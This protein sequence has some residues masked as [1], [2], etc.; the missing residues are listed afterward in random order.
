MGGL[1]N[2][3]RV[4]NVV[5]PT[6]RDYMKD[7]KVA[8]LSGISASACQSEPQ[9]SIMKIQLSRPLAGI[10][11]LGR[12]PMSSRTTTSVVTFLHPFVVAGYTGDL[13]AGDDVVLRA[14]RRTETFLLIN[15]HAGKLELRAVKQQGPGWLWRRIRPTQLQ[16]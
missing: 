4:T 1:R 13:P 5:F 16:T 9:P 2:V 6:P 11:C 14:Y 10:G 12:L 8:V 3:A 15:W 7:T